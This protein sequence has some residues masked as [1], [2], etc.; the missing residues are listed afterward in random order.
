MD[1]LW[2]LLGIQEARVALGYCLVQLLNFQLSDS[3]D[4]RRQLNVK[5]VLRRLALITLK[6]WKCYVLENH[7]YTLIILVL[8]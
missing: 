3:Q 6:E 5:L 2:K 4:F 7:S 8:P 1:A